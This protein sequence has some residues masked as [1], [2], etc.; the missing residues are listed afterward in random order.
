MLPS[1]A[2]VSARPITRVR[3]SACC[4]SS[5]CLCVL[6]P[7]FSTSSRSRPGCSETFIGTLPTLLPLIFTVAPSADEPAAAFTVSTAGSGFL[8]MV[9]VKLEV[10]VTFTVRAKGW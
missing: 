4:T 2:E 6:W 9:K 10:L 7:S 5:H 8:T 1:F 3:F